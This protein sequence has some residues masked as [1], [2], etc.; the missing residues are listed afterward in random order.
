MGHREVRPV[1]M[2][3]QHPQ[4]GGTYRDGT[5]RYVPLF[6]RADLRRDLAELDRQAEAGD[7]ASMEPVFFQDYM[8]EIPEG[9]P[10]GYQLYETTTEGTPVSPVFATLEE[11]AA[12]CER[13]ATVFRRDQFWTREQWLASFRN[14]TTDVDSL[15][16]GS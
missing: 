9:T 15:A 12:W 14:G 6:S 13:G 8:P 16:Y 7:L 3:W 10:Y 5:P 11:L 1:P 2:D 4:E